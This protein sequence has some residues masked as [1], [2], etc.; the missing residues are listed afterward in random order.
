M[1]HYICPK[2]RGYLS[3]DNEI[4]FITKT[5]NHDTA[6]VLL[7]AELG[8]YE[9]RKNSNVNFEPG[10]HVNFICPL[11][12]E[13]LNA[14]DVDQ[15]LAKVIMVEEDG[16]EVNVLFSKIVGEKCTYSIH[17]KGIKAFGD[18]ADKYISKL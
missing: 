3:V 13:N 12:Y 17:E 11:C 1:K 4:I 16:T 9:F 5:N 6:M 10:D 8:N 7:S 15:N 2:C 18:D 14:E